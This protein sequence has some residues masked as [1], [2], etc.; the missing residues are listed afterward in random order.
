MTTN[1]FESRLY[2]LPIETIDKLAVHDPGSVKAVLRGA[3]EHC[4]GIMSNDDKI[5]DIEFFY[6]NR[7]L[8]KPGF[9]IK[10]H[11]G[12]KH[13]FEL[14]LLFSNYISTE[15]PGL[16]LDPFKTY[17]T[18]LEYYKTSLEA[19]DIIAIN[20]SE[21]LQRGRPESIYMST[22]PIEIAIDF[23]A[24]EIYKNLL[25][26]EN[27]CEIQE[28]QKYVYLMFNPDTNRFKIGRSKKP[29][30]REK[31]LQSSEP[32]TCV[33]KFW[34]CPNEIETLLHRK[35]CVNRKRGEWFSL[36]FKEIAEF[37]ETVNTL[38]SNFDV[39]Q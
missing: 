2:E 24:A 19:N 39:K 26:P 31:T 13:F 21:I 33:L 22:E 36:N 8:E 9:L 27:Q 4:Y 16:D 23:S 14:L 1:D 20:A 10:L 28:G 32:K 5:I 30:Y 15:Y 35:Y 38:I 12:E 11:R 17:S 18:F 3:R 7:S 37:D 25:H 34:E 6:I 29:Y